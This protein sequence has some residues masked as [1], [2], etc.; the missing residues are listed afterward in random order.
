MSPTVVPLP[1]QGDVFVDADNP[2]KALRISWH[3]ETAVVVV[4]LWQADTCVGTL[5]LTP[6][7][8]PRLISALAEGLA[9]A[10]PGSSTVRDRDG[11]AS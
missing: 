1:S 3:H 4:S 9:V 6:D 5:R 7:E 8:V 10:Y 2:A 11:R